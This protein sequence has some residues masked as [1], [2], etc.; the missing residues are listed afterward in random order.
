[1]FNYR[2]MVKSGGVPALLTRDWAGGPTPTVRG[3]VAEEFIQR[4]ETGQFRQALD[5]QAW[6]KKRTCK[7]LS[8]SGALKVLHR[9]G[10]KLK[11]PRK[12][13][14][15]K[16][17]AKANAFKAELPVRLAELVGSVPTQP[18]RL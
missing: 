13:Y 5:A 11:V 4:L 18:V 9:L 2:D 6:I 10:G 7:T 8:V 12:S 16:D 3:A 14:T 1:M 17:P 15:K